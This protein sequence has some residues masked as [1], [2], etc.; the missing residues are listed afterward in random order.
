MAEIRNSTTG[1]IK[2]TNQEKEITIVQNFL[3]DKN[4]LVKNEMVGEKEFSIK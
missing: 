2:I 4:T 3:K 1:R